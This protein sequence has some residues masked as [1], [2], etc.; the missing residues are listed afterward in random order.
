MAV[1]QI[2]KIQVRRGKKNQSG[3]PQLASGEMAWA[4]DTQELYIGNGAVG[5]GAP[6]VG[7]SKI[8][9]EHDSI[10]N[11][12]GQY[13][14]YYD[15]EVGESSLA[16]TT[17]RSIQ[18]RLDDGSVNVRSFG[19]IPYPYPAGS[20][21][22][23]ASQTAKMQNAIIEVS[24][25]TKVTLEFDPGE[26]RF[27]STLVLPS[28]S[29][30]KGYG[31]DSTLLKFT[32]T[33]NALSSIDGGERI[34]L[35]D[36]SV[37][38]TLDNSSCLELTNTRN[39]VL[40]NVKFT[41]LNLDPLALPDAGELANNRVGLALLG[42][43]FI[44]NNKFSNVEFSQL[45][46]GVFTNGSSYNS[47]S[48]CNFDLLYKSILVGESTASNN[49]TF[50]FS[51]FDNITHEALEVVNGYGNKSIGNTFKNVGSSLSGT[52][53]SSS[54][55]LFHSHKN[56]SIGDIFE[57]P[58]YLQ[59]YSN[60]FSANAYLPEVDG[61]SYYAKNDPTKVLLAYAPT[62]AVAIT[63]PL[64]DLNGIKLNYVINSTEYE[65]YRRGTM[66]ILVDKETSTVELTDEY[67]VRGETEDSIVLSADIATQGGVKVLRIRYQNNVAFVNDRNEMS[68]TYSVLS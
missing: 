5:E 54:I 50:K 19:V 48:N 59:D 36:L 61:I 58:T 66:S 32:S 8:L 49:N 23:I 47:F 38:V 15:P 43:E 62:P 10:I 13:E 12:A 1:V 20:T 56:S 9:T 51:I 27:S 39:C 4:V 37:A 46:Y 16:G 31:K 35:Q 11:I 22:T 63:L 65:V 41:Y 28:N 7:N 55:I 53:S 64:K 30:I 26:Y 68:Y 2:S 24:S 60:P 45:T 21:E 18:N 17:R 40:E 42:A 44:S 34:M 6:Y 33:T 14:Y 25:N 52:Y 3:M 67:E 57:R 29:R